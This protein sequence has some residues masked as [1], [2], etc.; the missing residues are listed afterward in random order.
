MT[1]NEFTDELNKWQKNYKMVPTDV[2]GTIYCY[3]AKEKESA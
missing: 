1:T 2:F 3:I